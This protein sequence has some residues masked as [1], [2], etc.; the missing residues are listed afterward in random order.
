[1]NEATTNVAAILAE[2]LA[3]EGQGRYV[4]V[5]GPAH[6]PDQVKAMRAGAVR[7][8]NRVL[9]ARDD[10]LGRVRV[11]DPTVDKL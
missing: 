9:V 7:A 5:P 8:L 2:Q 4:V 10:D 6:T 1:M 3:R 11:V